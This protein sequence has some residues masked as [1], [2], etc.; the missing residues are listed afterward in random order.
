MKALFVINPSS[1]KQ[2]IESTL[3]EIMSTLILDQITST[4]DVFYTKKKDDAKNR[5]ACLKA[6]EYD[7]VVAVGGDGTLNE[8]SNGLVTS[9]S[10][11][12]LAIISAGTVNDFATYMKLPQDAAG[13]CEMI[14]DFSTKLVDIGRVNNEYF[15]NVLAGGLLTDIAY[16][17]PKDKKAVL[18]KMAYYLEGAKEL[19]KQFAKHMVLNYD[20]KEFSETT[21][22]M[23]FLVANSKSV[24]GFGDAA[25]LASVS[26]GY[27]DVMILKK[28]DFLTAPD[29]LFKLMQGAHP[30][31]PSI[32]YFQ[33]KEITIDQTSDEHEIAIDYDGEILSEGFPVHI[34]IV[35]EALNILV[36]RSNDD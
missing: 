6:G 28:I 32:E 20:A 2:N 3:Q 36:S 1:G 18:G 33:T 10:H 12:P 15:I 21:E 5:V 35:P 25:P 8:V 31:H 16:K 23:V 17:V 27:L 29:L 7:Y 22:T 34:S 9:K 4:I 11:T 14:K 30:N 24:G 13:F 19:P 26:D